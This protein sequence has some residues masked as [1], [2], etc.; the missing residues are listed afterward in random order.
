MIKKSL[1]AIAMVGCFGVAT[2]FSAN[3]AEAKLQAIGNTVDC[4]SASSGTAIGAWFYDCG[5]PK[6]PKV[7]GV[8][9]G[10]SQKC[11]RG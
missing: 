10:S 4:Y 1:F 8:H 3:S 7:D 9:S 5:T 11:D 2:L 6:C